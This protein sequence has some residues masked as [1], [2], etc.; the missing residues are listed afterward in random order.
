RGSGIGLT[1]VKHI[2]EAHN[3][4]IQ[5]ESEIGKGSTFSVILPITNT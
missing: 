1:L 4:R 5:V 3:G 2:T